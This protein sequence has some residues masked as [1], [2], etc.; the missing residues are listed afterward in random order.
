MAGL[1]RAMGQGQGTIG[2]Q[3]EERY[4]LQKVKLGQ[5]SFG[6][7]WRAVDRQHGITVAIK[8]LDKASLPRR[9]VTRQD[10]EREISMMKACSHENIT[11]LYDNFE[12]T[13]SIYLAL[14]YCDGGDFGDKVK[15][16][17]MG[18][19]EVEVAE[20]CRQMCAAICAL[21]TRGICHRDIKPDN[22]MVSGQT[23]T[24]LKLSDFG[25]AIFLPRGK[26]LQEKCGTPAFMAPEQHHLPKRSPGYSF[27]VDI[28]A[29]GVS[30]Y[31]MFFGGKHP[32]LN[33]RGHLDDNLLLS[34][35]LDFRDQANYNGFFGF[36]ARSLRF[37]EDARKLCKSMVEPESSRRVTSEDAMASPW[38]LIGL[39]RGRDSQPAQASYV[40]V[41]AEHKDDPAEGRHRT[42]TPRRRQ[43]RALNDAAI[44]DKSSGLKG[45]SPA[46]S[47]SPPDHRAFREAAKLKEQNENLQAELDERKRREEQ[48]V[49]QQKQLQ[50]QQKMLQ[51]QR[52]KELQLQNEKL[53]E[54]EKQLQRIEQEKL[55]L[56]MQRAKEAEQTAA[57]DRKSRA[58]SSVSRQR[59]AMGSPVH[60][61]CLRRGLKCRYESGTYGWMPCVVQGY[62]ESDNTYNLDVRQHAALDKISPV[63]DVS[64]ME[65]W[66]PGTLAT[67]H[68]ATVN[69]WLPAVVLT[70]NEEDGTYNLDVRDHADVDRIR[71]RVSIGDG[72]DQPRRASASAVGQYLTEEAGDSSK[73]VRRETEL[74]SKKSSLNRDGSKGAPLRVSDLD[75]AGMATGS[76]PMPGG[77]RKVGQGDRCVIPEHGTVVIE[78][79]HDGT[80]TVKTSDRQ[81]LKVQVDVMRAPEDAKFAWPPNTKVSYQSASLRGKW[82]DANVVSFNANNATYNLDV[83]MEAAP[84]K[85]RPR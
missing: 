38:L 81:R 80:Y 7:V 68:S 44:L 49:Q 22:F 55:E 23:Q 53:I 51:Q 6:T 35:E 58:S 11:E 85:V 32:F 61:G 29:T 67:Y 39:D 19:E 74:L 3:L 69:T 15:E 14:E 45:R 8:Q 47:P 33:D 84:D 16:R 83:R 43:A 18:V 63:A 64:A 1:L 24:K 75:A 73:Y 72:E 50:M 79:L 25:L 65:A 59:P 28:W 5:G 20:W 66:P 56:E 27:P 54:Q 41:D 26:L 70:F 17:G 21:H 76:V 31:M 40:S 34:G 10:I 60:A 30:I 42:P 12:D 48:L 4:F 2:A 71:A 46:S 36:G 82:I 62:N 77:G 52:T 9:G 57:V 78:S 13:N 37:S